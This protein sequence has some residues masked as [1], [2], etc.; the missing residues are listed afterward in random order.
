[1]SI[2][3]DDDYESLDELQTTKPKNTVKI[4]YPLRNNRRN[5]LGGQESNLVFF[6]SFFDLHIFHVLKAIVQ[7][8]KA[9]Y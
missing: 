3:R 2:F 4:K 6:L 8:S 7:K 5:N 9:D 1:M